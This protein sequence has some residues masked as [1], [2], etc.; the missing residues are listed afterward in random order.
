MVVKTFQSWFFNG[1]LKTLINYGALGVIAAWLMYNAQNTFNSLI[2]DSRQNTREVTAAMRELAPNLKD[3]C[4]KA[5]KHYQAAETHH[6]DCEHTAAQVDG[7][8]RQL[9]AEPNGG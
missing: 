2:E 5:D 6:K 3:L 8:A 9:G 4:N 7:I 1:G